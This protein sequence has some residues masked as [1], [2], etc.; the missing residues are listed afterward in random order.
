MRRRHVL[1]TSVFCLPFL[2][3]AAMAEPVTITF[4]HTNDIYEISPDDGQGGFGE[5]ATLL[6]RERAANP[7]TVT[8]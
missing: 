8:T 5:L 1:A 6:E 4:L 7:L 3:T 2:A